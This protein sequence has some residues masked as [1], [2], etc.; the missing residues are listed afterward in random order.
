MSHH[1]TTKVHYTD[2]SLLETFLNKMHVYDI[3]KTKGVV[4][5]YII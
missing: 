1:I 5:I 4:Y 3:I 2:D